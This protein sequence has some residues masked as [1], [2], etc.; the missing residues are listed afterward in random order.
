MALAVVA[1]CACK[2]ART[3]W[4]S[5]GSG[6]TAALG[7]GDG[8][9]RLGLPLPD[10]HTVCDV[11]P[12]GAVAEA[13]GLMVD[14]SFAHTETGTA[15]CVY[16]NTTDTSIPSVSVIITTRSTI[17]DIRRD[18]ATGEAM[19]QMQ[20]ATWFVDAAPGDDAASLYVDAG[21]FVLVVA[22][23]SSVPPPRRPAIA[24]EVAREALARR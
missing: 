18:H 24:V 11:L 20:Q 17:Q 13:S 22:V 4:P 3:P 14:K 1:T 16:S 6:T 7:S 10:D 21:A 5:A 19:P 15:T 9:L 23:E 2:K 12:V 8:A